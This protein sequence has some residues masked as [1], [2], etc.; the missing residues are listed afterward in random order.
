LGIQ[1]DIKR[2]LEHSVAFSAGSGAIIAPNWESLVINGDN[3]AEAIARQVAKQ[4]VDLIVMS[5]R[6]RPLR[7]AFLGSTT[8]QVCHTA[9]CSVFVVHP[10]EPEWV[11]AS[12]GIV[13]LQ[14]L[15]VAFDFSACA[16][17]ALRQA[18]SLARRYRAEVHLLHVLAERERE[19]SP[20][21]RWEGQEGIRLN[22]EDRLRQAVPAAGTQSCKITYAVSE[23]KAYREV[24]AY[25]KGKEVEL[26]AIGA[27]GTRP[28][29]DPFFGSNVDR[30]LR[31][32]PC[33]VLVARTAA[34]QGTS[35]F[36]PWAPD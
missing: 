32:S 31:R 16:E 3:P 28:G 21:I 19:S 27:R 14:R 35:D 2:L 13:E 17:L 4:E 12:A 6:R 11:D 22:I 18:L 26:I 1:E 5:S 30:V 7:A 24:L 8:E 25:A 33:P 10:N 29:T 34:I 23:G 15:L 20:E 36:E 9:P